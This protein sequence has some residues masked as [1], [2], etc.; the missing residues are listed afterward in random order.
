MRMLVVRPTEDLSVVPYV[1][2]R[3]AAEQLAVEVGEFAVEAACH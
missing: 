2:V 3:F 1:V